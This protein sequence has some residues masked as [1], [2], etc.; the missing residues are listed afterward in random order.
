MLID[1]FRYFE[2]HYADTISMPILIC[3]VSLLMPCFCRYAFFHYYSSRRY[4]ILPDVH[5]AAMLPRH[6]MLLMPDIPCHA[7]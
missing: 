2:R 3:H 7:I 4:S 6:A 1:A 5:A